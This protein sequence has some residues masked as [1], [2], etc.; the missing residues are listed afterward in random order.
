MTSHANKLYYNIEMK[1]TQSIVY[2]QFRKKLHI[3]KILVLYIIIAKVF[4][5]HTERCDEMQ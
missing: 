3:I 4:L 1:S 2:H 5:I